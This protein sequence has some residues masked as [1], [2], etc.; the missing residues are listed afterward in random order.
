MWKCLGQILLLPRRRQ[1]SNKLL[2]DFSR[3]LEQFS[4]E[5]ERMMA[6]RRAPYESAGFQY[7]RDSGAW[8]IQINSVNA[9][10]PISN[11]CVAVRFPCEALPAAVAI[12]GWKASKSCLGADACLLDGQKWTRASLQFAI[13]D[14]KIDQTDPYDQGTPGKFYASHAERQL[15][16]NACWHISRSNGS[17]SFDFKC[18]VNKPVC[19]E[20]K[21]FFRETW[22]LMQSRGPGSKRCLSI[23]INGPG[24]DVIHHAS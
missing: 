21:E 17:I 9:R 1:L 24:G 5:L 22:D 13:E 6:V 16:M 4:R 14:L 23:T 19:P 11:K 15:F 8:V 18:A 7:D 20:C 2:P 12:S 3:L 10:W